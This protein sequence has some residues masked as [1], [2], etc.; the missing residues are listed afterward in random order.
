MPDTQPTDLKSQHAR[1]LT[2][3][4]H[5]IN[6][7]TLI[8]QAEYVLGEVQ[9]LCDAVG[10]LAQYDGYAERWQ[11]ECELADV[12]LSAVTLANMLGVT[13]EYCIAEKTE[14]DRGRG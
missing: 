4:G 7:T 13:I 12:V 1:Y 2:E 3:R 9:E 5:T 10:D 8:G 14:A 11:V 6:Q